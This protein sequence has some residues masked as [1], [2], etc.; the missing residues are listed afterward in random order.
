MIFHKDRKINKIQ[1]P[2]TG[3]CNRRCPHCCAREKLTWFNKSIIKKEVTIDEL[4][5]AGEQL[6]P[7]EQ[8]ELTGGEPTLH[9]KF[10]EITSNLSN[11]FRCNDFMLVSNGWLFH[12]NPSK[13]ELLLKYNRILIT[14]YGDTF[15]KNNGGSTN[16]KEA[17]I[18]RNFLTAN[19]HQNFVIAE[20]DNHKEYHAGPYKGNPCAQF[21]SG[22]ISYYEKYLYGCCVAWSLENQGKGILLTKSWRNELYDID[23][24][25]EHCYLSI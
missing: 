19:K 7:V 11:I 18:I 22:M 5:W 25:C 3:I 23:V 20:L 17:D 1:I 12:H 16:N 2:I 10:E 21:Y 9:S 4:K 15:S 6:G 13:L 24:P 14:H 8:I